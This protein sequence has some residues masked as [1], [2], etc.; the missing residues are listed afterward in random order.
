M[1]SPQSKIK[2]LVSADVSHK[3]S[4][5][6]VFGNVSVDKIV[7]DVFLCSFLINRLIFLSLTQTPF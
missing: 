4:E 3:V 5:V 6:V 7:C 1:P 2:L